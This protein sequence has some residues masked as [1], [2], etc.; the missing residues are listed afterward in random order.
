MH[1]PRE[2]RFPIKESPG[3]VI[4]CAEE[5]LRD[6]ITYWFTS[7][8]VRTYPTTDGYEASRILK[9]TTVGL[10]ITDRVLPPWP[11]LDTFRQLRSANPRLRVAFVDDGTRDG[12]ILA[13]ITGATVVLTRPLS[14]RQVIEALGLPELV[15]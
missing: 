10:L 9:T 2:I 6:V 12:V 8:S 13:R 11:G 1:V 14:R 3:V 15:P 5:E 4:L 7:L